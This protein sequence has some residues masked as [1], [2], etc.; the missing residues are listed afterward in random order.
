[1]IGV[2]GHAGAF[3]AGV[4]SGAIVRKVDVKCSPTLRFL[5]K[6]QS[7]E[8]WGWKSGADGSCIVPPRRLRRMARIGALSGSMPYAVCVLLELG[9]RTCG[10]HKSILPAA[11][12]GEE[13]CR[14]NK[15]GPHARY[16]YDKSRYNASSRIKAKTESSFAIST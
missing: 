14:H 5:N 8:S 2:C 7:G 16:F 6:K 12:S 1:M 9:G 11:H 10:G 3:W 4:W 13:K 15:T